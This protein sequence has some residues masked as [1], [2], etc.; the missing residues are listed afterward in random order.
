MPQLVSDY[1]TYMQIFGGA[2]DP[3]AD[4]GWSCSPLEAN[5]DIELQ[6]PEAISGAATT[7]YYTFRFRTTQNNVRLA[8][9]PVALV[10]NQPVVLNLRSDI[11]RV[12]SGVPF[13]MYVQN[14]QVSYA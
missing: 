2:A 10:A 14:D 8:A 1:D 11:A 5:I 6:S 12:A 13:E 4:T 7:A 9:D 3:V